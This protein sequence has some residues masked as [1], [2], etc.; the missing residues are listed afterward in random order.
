MRY[1]VDTVVMLPVHLS[2]EVEADSLADALVAANDVPSEG[3]TLGDPERC[4]VEIDLDTCDTVVTR[5][6][7][8]GNAL[9]DGGGAS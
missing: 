2:L 5:I 1:R 9:P 7:G 3:W 8:C 6:D 4:D